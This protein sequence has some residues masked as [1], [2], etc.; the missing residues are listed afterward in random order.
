MTGART[1]QPNWLRRLLARA[2]AR[3]LAVFVV[4]DAGVARAAGLDLLS[5][6]LRIVTTPRHARV[7]LLVGQVS[8][9]LER[10]AA[11]VYAQMPRPRSILG[12]GEQ[13]THRLP[14]P[15]VTAP[16]S[17]AGLEAAVADL[18]QLLAE[19]AFSPDTA[20]FDVDAVRTETEY[21]CPM[22]PEVVQSEPGSCPICGMDLVPREVAPGTERH[23]PTGTGHGMM[24]HGPE[25][26]AGTEYTCPMHPE[27]VQSEPGSCPICG[28]T[29]TPRQDTHAEQDEHT[30]SRLEASHHTDH[31]MREGSDTDGQ[32]YS[33]PM[34]P[35]IV[36]SE[37][38]S[39][40]ICGMRLVPQQDVVKESDPAG[41][42]MDQT[43]SDHAHHRVTH[44]HHDHV[45]ASSTSHVE[46]A[47]VDERHTHTM[48]NDEPSTEHGIH[49]PDDSHGMDH[50]SAEMEHGGHAMGHGD[51]AM[52]DHSS[53]GGGGFMS[54]VAMTQG[55]P[56]SSDGL[57]MEWAEAPFGP[58]FP[59]LPGG[60]MLT[61]T[62][63]GDTVADAQA[64]PGTARRDLAATW[65]GD[66]HTLPARFASLDLLA[67]DAYAV[68]AWQAIQG[69]T[70][71]VLDEEAQ[72]GR[73]G[74]LERARAI[75]HLG[76]LAAFGGLLGYQWLESEAG[77]LQL[78]LVRAANVSAV[79][80]M[81]EGVQRL[82]ERTDRNRMLR[83]RLAGIGVV[84]PAAGDL[85]GPVARADGQ[86]IDSR[87]GDPAY[88]QLGFHP[89]TRSGSDALARMEVRLGEILQSLDLIHSVNTF[90]LVAS[91]SGPIDAP[92]MMA[93]LEMPR[94]QATVHAALES[95]TAQ[96]VHVMT[97]STAHLG[98]I[99]HVAVGAELADALVGI[100]SLD[101][102]PWEI[103]Q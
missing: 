91:D 87:A 40:P 4:P 64:L 53:H 28:M 69:S 100:A 102:S 94:G 42:A 32:T 51:H 81:R 70:G 50:N 72:R 79:A 96:A 37:P 43:D 98:L 13:E 60:L 54:M 2:S 39:C 93:T 44:A 18:R 22:H 75:S 57:P 5:A 41:P 23:E 3:S 65:P 29:L 66:V 55:L 97:P 92:A 67:P 86:H 77:T 6:G 20:D 9:D 26:A 45:I 84:T 33:C 61:L 74:A 27:I 46:L 63:D 12:V 85:T 95:G 47:S 25:A 34:H 19:G 62:L 8:D 82:I 52:M 30:T 83:R 80:T 68:L 49:H 21:V 76:W 90:T 89:I 56:R 38:G 73:V 7:L 103:D 14:A 11:V 99:P 59:G 16:F 101:I 88:Q 58:L 31:G 17:Q 78:S 15:D 24:A 71:R 48:G 36:R 10:A 35:E 1:G